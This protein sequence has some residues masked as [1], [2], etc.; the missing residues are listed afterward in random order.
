MD[1]NLWGREVGF[2]NLNTET[3]SIYIILVE[4]VPKFNSPALS[5]VTEPPLLFAFVIINQVF[6]YDKAITRIMC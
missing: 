1:G 4:L 3:T 6:S 2:L 5:S